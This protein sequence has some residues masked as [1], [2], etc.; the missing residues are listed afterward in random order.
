MFLW[1]CHDTR[2]VAKLWLFKVTRALVIDVV[3]TYTTA[4]L[5]SSTTVATFSSPWICFSTAATA[6]S[7]SALSSNTVTLH[8]R[9]QISKQG[10]IIQP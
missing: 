2:E 4:F 7:A 10:G 8:V 1:S 3:A 5:S 9:M 6:W